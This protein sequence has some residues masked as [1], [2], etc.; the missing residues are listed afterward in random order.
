MEEPSGEQ[1]L[2]PGA[3]IHTTGFALLCTFLVLL[4]TIKTSPVSGP[5]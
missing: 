2:E 5:E 3:S 4:V 1:E